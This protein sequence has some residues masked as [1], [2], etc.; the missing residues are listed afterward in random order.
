MVKLSTGLISPRV[1]EKRP[2]T[3][4]LLGDG[5]GRRGQKKS[6]EGFVVLGL[7]EG[8]AP[9]AGKVPNKGT[10]LPGALGIGLR[11][12]PGPCF[13]SLGVS[14]LSFSCCFSRDGTLRPLVSF[15]HPQSGAG[16]A[17]LGWVQ[18][19]S[20][21][22][23]SPTVASSCK[24]SCTAAAHIV[25][26]VLSRSTTHERSRPVSPSGEFRGSLCAATVE[27]C[28]WFE[29]LDKPVTLAGSRAGATL[30]IPHCCSSPR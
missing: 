8:R 29:L 22:K 16:L 12:R 7:R 4:A 24:P 30:I 1:H 18:P 17:P 21:A 28:P 2:G 9:S 23:E 11:G 19:A 25:H 6:F 10:V 3:L 26:I 20:T 27:P 13:T 15:Q 5:G 14:H